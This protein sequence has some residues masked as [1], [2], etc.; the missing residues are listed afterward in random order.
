MTHALVFGSFN[1]N[2]FLKNFKHIFNNNLKEFK[3]YRYRTY[4]R[5]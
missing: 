2:I 4:D 1:N 5:N 3:H